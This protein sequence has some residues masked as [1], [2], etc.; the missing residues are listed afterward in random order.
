VGLAVRDARDVALP[1]PLL[2]VRDARDVALPAPLLAVRDARDVA[3]PAPLLAARER[4]A[5]LAPE[6]RLDAEP[7]ARRAVPPLWDALAAPLPEPLAPLAP[8]LA[9]PLAPLLAEPL[10]PL[11][12]EPLAPLLAEPLGLL[13]LVRRGLLLLDSLLLACRPRPEPR[14]VD[15][16]LAD[17]E[18]D[19]PFDGA[20]LVPRSLS[21]AM[22]YLPFE[23]GL[24]RVAGDT[25]TNGV[26]RAGRQSTTPWFPDLHT[27]M[28]ACIPEIEAP[29]T[30]VSYV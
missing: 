10:A 25:G 12:A 22:L 23:L 16:P 26:T 4:D 11:L 13:L 19:R 21:T 14:L 17:F 30:G 6:E 8:L 3:L 7:L 28:V 2:A 1:A 9:E 18:D 24:P 20:R 27:R 29:L 15:V 5:G